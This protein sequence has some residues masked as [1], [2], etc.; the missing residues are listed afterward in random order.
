MIHLHVL[1]RVYSEKSTFVDGTSVV[2]LYAIGKANK[3]LVFLHACPTSVR[4]HGQTGIVEAHTFPLMI[5]VM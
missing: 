3:K 2:S 5:L 4:Y 1:S